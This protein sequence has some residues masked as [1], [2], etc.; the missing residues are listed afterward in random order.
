[1]ENEERVWELMRDGHAEASARLIARLE[2]ERD[3]AVNARD[4]AVNERDAAVNER[5]AAVNEKD[6][7]VNEKKAA[8]KLAERTVLAAIDALESNWSVQRKLR[9]LSIMSEGLAEA[10]AI[11]SLTQVEQDDGCGDHPEGAGSEEMVH[12]GQRHRHARAAASRA[13]A[14]ADVDRLG[15]DGGIADALGWQALMADPDAKSLCGQIFKIHM[16]LGFAGRKEV[17]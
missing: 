8:I 12:R 6:A 1:M 9:M 5:D 7:A 16:L 17:V 4:G 15:Q 11:F 13:H 14:R 3:G 2:A 10:L